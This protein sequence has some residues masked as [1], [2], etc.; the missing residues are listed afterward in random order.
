MTIS[1]LKTGVHVTPE[2]SRISNIHTQWTN[3]NQHLD[4][5]DAQPIPVSARS[6]VHRFKY[7]DRRFESRLWHY[8]CPQRRTA[9]VCCSTE[10]AL[11]PLCTSMA[12]EGVQPHTWEI[13]S[14]YWNEMYKCRKRLDVV[15]ELK[16]SSCQ[17]SHSNFEMYGNAANFKDSRSVSRTGMWING[18]WRSVSWQF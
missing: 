13:L 18:I 5:P 7:P 2:T 17:G 14:P 3:S 15:T 16:D 8:V 1:P 6:E 4:V 9:A 10:G 12:S 11:P